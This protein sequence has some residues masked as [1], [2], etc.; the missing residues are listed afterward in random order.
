MSDRTKI[1]SVETEQAYREILGRLSYYSK[2]IRSGLPF[3]KTRRIV[4][5][6]DRPGTL[7]GW[8]I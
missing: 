2:A 6:Q 8:V 1:R 3:P 4:F 5:L 7:P